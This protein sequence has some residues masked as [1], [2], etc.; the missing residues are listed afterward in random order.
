MK[1]KSKIRVLTLEGSPKERGRVHG[2]TLEPLILEILER[3]K[4]LLKLSFKEDPDV[5]IDDFLENTNFMPAIKKWAPQLLEEVEG[6]AEGMGIDF[7]EIYAMHLAAH[8][9]KWWFDQKNLHSESCTSLGS[10]KKKEQPAILAQNM[11]LGQ[12]FEG[13]EVLLHIK[14]PNSSL[15]ALV[16]SH[17]GFLAECGLNNQP[18]GIC[19]NSLTSQLNNSIDGLPVTFI[20]RSVLEQSSLEKAVEFVHEIKHASGQNYMIG[21]A[22]KIVCLEC[23]ANKV[24]QF[25]PYENAKNVYH[26]N[27]ALV[28]DDYIEYKKKHYSRSTSEQRFDY[29]E[30]RLSDPSKKITV[31]TV[32]GILSSHFGPVCVH[33]NSQPLLIFTY[34]SVVYSLST[35]PTLYITVGPPCMAEYERFDL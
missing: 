14:Y 34:S 3:Y 19:C 24:S 1:T 4:Y 18:V 8:D 28:N 33:H 22:E 2:E 6:V 25:I 15:E 21:G 32:K 30:S 13:Y 35:P 5:M 11:D 12:L 27:H 17:A 9:E 20:V 29:L 23:S 26:T 7:K 16:L 10:F 31:E